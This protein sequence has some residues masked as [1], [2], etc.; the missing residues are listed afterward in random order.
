MA[1][2]R[3]WPPRPYRFSPCS[4]PKNFKS[5]AEIQVGIPHDPDRSIRNS[6]IGEK[7]DPKVEIFENLAFCPVGLAC[8]L[9]S[10]PSQGLKYSLGCTGPQLIP[11]PRKSGRFWA[12]IIDLKVGKTSQHQPKSAKIDFFWKKVQICVLQAE[13]ACLTLSGD[14]DSHFVVKSLI[15][16]GLGQYLAVLGCHLYIS[17][18]MVYL[19]EVLF[20]P[21]LTYM[22]SKITMIEIFT[23]PP[24]DQEGYAVPNCQLA[25]SYTNIP[26]TKG[27][28]K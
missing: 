26:I 18:L 19:C 4:Y 14:R 9:Q 23:K 17:V 21:I 22:H 12:P 15:L 20:Q 25:A 8:L 5:Q 1:D 6:P 27:P 11:W 13:M 28:S 24:W 7:F 10:L 3:F 2:H 16:R